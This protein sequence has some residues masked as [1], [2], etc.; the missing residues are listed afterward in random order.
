[1]YKLSLVIPIYKVEQYIH[2]CLESLLSQL[3]R[4]VEVICVNDGTPDTSIQ[5][6]K[7]LIKTYSQEIQS[8][9]LFIDQSNQG[10]SAARNTGISHA[11]GEYIGFLDSDDKIQP[12]YFNLV[13]PVL[14]DSHYDIIDFNIITS[15]DKLIKTRK[16][17]FDSVFSL[18]NWYCPARIFKTELIKSSMFKTGL[19]YEDLELTPRLYIKAQETTHLNEALYWYRTNESSITQSLSHTNNIK[20]IESIENIFD[21]YIELYSETQNP[22]YAVLLL[23][24]YFMLCVSACRRF[25]VQKSFM[26]I[27]KYRSYIKQIKIRQLPV[28]YHLIDPKIIAFY[29]APKP[30]ILLYSSYDRFRNKLNS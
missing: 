19:Y 13:L 8:Q 20:T 3:P 28:E 2:E 5:I 24:C 27:N 9:F 18:M 10:L 7:N 14:R 15:E 4:D 21:T 25:N 11:S 17:S 6:A 12:N 22:Y 16:D 23:Q 1:M 29:K 30:Y 26:Y